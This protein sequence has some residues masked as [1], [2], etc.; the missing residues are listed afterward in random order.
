MGDQNCSDEYRCHSCLNKTFQNFS[1]LLNHFQ[2]ESKF[3]Y[4]F[5]I[6]INFYFKIIMKKMK[7]QLVYY[8]GKKDVIN[9]L[10]V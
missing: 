3:F 4:L 9:I 10:I 8:V 1:L 6:K 7:N 2:D 5:N